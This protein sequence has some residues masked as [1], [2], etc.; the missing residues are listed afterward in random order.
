M[1]SRPK[2]AEPSSPLSRLPFERMQRLHQL[3]QK[4]R[5]PNAPKVAREFEV[6][7]KSIHRDLEFM[8]DRLGLPIGYD[9]DRHGYYY[10]E[11]VGAFPTIQVT[12]GEL[13]AMVVA[14]K[15]LQQYRGTNFEKPLMTAFKKMS[16]SLSDTVSVNIAD[17]EQ[18]ISFSTRAEPILNLEIFDALG[19]AAANRQQLELIYRKP[20]QRETE[21]RVIDPYH[22][23]NINGEWYLFAYDHL[24]NDIRTFVPARIKAFK[25]TGK[26]FPRPQKFSL[27]KRLRNSFG[28]HSAQGDFRVVIRFA[29]VVADYIRE[30]KWHHSQELIELEDG[31]VELRLRLSSLQ[32]I[33]RWILGWGGNAVVVEP[34]ELADMVRRSAGNILKNQG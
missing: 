12:E 13:L 14:E 23:A 18:T 5:Y 17:F 4:G 11:E 7:S 32:E 22:L 21:V 19:K 24:R 29:E 2:A 10:T 27:E 26:R 1:K 31:G 9:Q 6:S 30:K 16:A 8:R 25:L 34:R 15:A 3:I 33:E 28:V 20:G